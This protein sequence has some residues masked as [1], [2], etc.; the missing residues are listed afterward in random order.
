MSERTLEGGASRAHVRSSD[1]SRVDWIA[2]AGS[3]SSS[4]FFFED[5]SVA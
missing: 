3:P 1:D 2:H 5:G 4:R